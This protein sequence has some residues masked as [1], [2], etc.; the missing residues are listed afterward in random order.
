[1]G[2]TLPLIKGL[3]L[4]RLSCVKKTCL[5]SFFFFSFNA[6]PGSLQDYLSLANA[7]TG[8]DHEDSSQVEI[9]EFAQPQ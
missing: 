7:Q 1:M 4:P 6:K 8:A 9:H 3:P 2:C 5:A